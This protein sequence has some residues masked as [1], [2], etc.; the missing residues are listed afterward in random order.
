MNIY[1]IRQDN[2][3]FYKIGIT[4]K[5]PKERISELQVGNAN[6]ITLIETFATKHGFKFEAVIHAEFK[7]NKV[8]DGGSEWFEL[9]NEHID[10]FNDICIAKESLLDFMKNN[11]HFWAD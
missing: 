1:L 4:K 7:L 5:N 11:N 9:S 3:N 8:K 2:T 6:H 10:S